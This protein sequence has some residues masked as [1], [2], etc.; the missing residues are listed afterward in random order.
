MNGLVNINNNNIINVENIRGYVDQTSGTVFLNLEDVAFG[1]G[2][3]NITTA[4]NEVVRWAR[5]RDHLGSIGIVATCGHGSI[6]SRLPEYIPENVFYMLAMKTSNPVAFAFQQKI[7]NEILPMIRRTGMYMTENVYNELMNNP[8][9]L[10]HMLT[11]INFFRDKLLAEGYTDLDFFGEPE[12]FI[13]EYVA[14]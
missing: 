6:Q 7:A 10:G 5:V 13:S 4:G 1:L 9:R 3:T 8:G 11:G 2:I 12:G 14:A